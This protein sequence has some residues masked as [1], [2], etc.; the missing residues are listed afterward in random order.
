M[1]KDTCPVVKLLCCFSIAV[2][3]IRLHL[4]FSRLCIVNVHNSVIVYSECYS[5]KQE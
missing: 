3:Y 2:F 1:G 5:K 4:T